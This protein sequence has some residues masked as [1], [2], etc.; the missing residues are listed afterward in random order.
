MNWRDKPTPKSDY[1]LEFLAESDKAWKV[2][3][4]RTGEMWIPKSQ[5]E[6]SESGRL[7]RGRTY[8]FTIP[9]WLAENKGLG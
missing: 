4:D 1:D 8:K 2:Q 3:G 9:D 7:V 5:C 6:V